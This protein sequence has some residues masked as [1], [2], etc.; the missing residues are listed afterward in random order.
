LHIVPYEWKKLN[1]KKLLAV[2]QFIT[3]ELQTKVAL[4]KKLIVYRTNVG[5]VES[6]KL[7]LAALTVFKI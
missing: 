3:E 5:S 7:N 1:C 4:N 2:N 6:D